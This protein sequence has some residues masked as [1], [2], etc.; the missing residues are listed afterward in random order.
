MYYLSKIGG[1]GW[2]GIAENQDVWCELGEAVVCPAVAKGW[3]DW[4]V[5][6]YAVVLVLCVMRSFITVSINIKTHE[7]YYI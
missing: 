7:I 3:T 1:V 4:L 6:W 5:Y 2:L